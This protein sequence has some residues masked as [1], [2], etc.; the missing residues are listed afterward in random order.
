MMHEKIWVGYSVS[1]CLKRIQIKLLYKLK[2]IA[3]KKT[4]FYRACLQVN[5]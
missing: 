3:L 1:I 2:A 5:I 4:H